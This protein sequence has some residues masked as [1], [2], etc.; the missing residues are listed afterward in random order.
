MIKTKLKSILDEKHITQKELAAK[1]DLRPN[2]IGDICANT[3][4]V[5][6]KEHLSKIMK[7]LE[8]KS[9]DDILEID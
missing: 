7:E 1:I 6:N 9:F 5:I 3:K 4:T 2:A 8:I